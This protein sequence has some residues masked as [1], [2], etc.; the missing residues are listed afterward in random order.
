MLPTSPGFSGRVPSSVICWSNH[1]ISST[2]QY[3][4]SPMQ[5]RPIST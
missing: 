4:P 1:L 2:D 5:S 3:S